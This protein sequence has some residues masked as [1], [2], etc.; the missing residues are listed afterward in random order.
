MPREYEKRRDESNDQW[1]ARV[2][3]VRVNKNGDF[4]STDDD[5]VATKNHAVS[6]LADLI[7]EAHPNVDRPSALHF[8]LHTANGA[9]LIARTRKR[10]EQQMTSFNPE[11]SM[12]IAKGAPTN[13]V[14]CVAKDLVTGDPYQ[15]TNAAAK[16]AHPDMTEARAFAKFVDDNPVLQRYAFT[17]VGPYSYMQNEPLTK[18]GPVHGPTVSLTPVYTGGEE[19]NRVRS[20]PANVPYPPDIGNVANDAYSQLVAL[21]NEQLKRRNLSSA[22][23]A[24]VFS[25]LYTSPDNLQLAMMERRQNR[26]GGQ[27]RDTP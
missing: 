12:I 27:A 25:E 9:S 23:F 7:C 8:L 22:H 21:T 26:P 6:T 20:S 5:E 14:D 4:V 16:A 18:V 19:G 24:R 13:F 15:L 11:Q 1:L 10:E 17:P 2:G 3:T